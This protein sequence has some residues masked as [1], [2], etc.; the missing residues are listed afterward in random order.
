M[1]EAS[2]YNL[3]LKPEVS[4]GKLF[5]SQFKSRAVKELK[6]PICVKGKLLS[7]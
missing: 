7:T 4:V 3:E 6:T 1:V 5:A 2:F